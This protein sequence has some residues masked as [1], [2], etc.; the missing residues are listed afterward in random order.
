MSNQAV[1]PMS[2]PGGLDAF[3]APAT[4]EAFLR[5]SFGQSWRHMP[6]A[7]EK[8]A[9]VFSMDEFSRLLGMDVWSARTMTIML[10]GRR[11]PPNAFCEQTVNRT[12]A[13]G[14]YPRRDRVMALMDEG[15]SVVLDEMASL[16]PGVQ[17]IADMLAGAFNARV[18][19]NLYYSQK[20]R[21][22]FA[23]HYDRHEVFALQIVGK[24]R[25]RV[26]RGQEDA[27]IEHPRFLNVPQAEYDKKK[28]QLDREVTTAPGDVLYLP[29]GQFHDA[30]AMDGDSL[31]ITFSVLTP[32]G[33]NLVQD[34]VLR[35][36]DEPL[37]R[38]DLPRPD[39]PDGEAALEQHVDQLVARLADIYSGKNGRDIAKQL[40]KGF[41]SPPTPPYRLPTK[42]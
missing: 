7:P 13:G 35:L 23:S 31:H 1:F 14:L 17:G 30:L 11:A 16:A 34:M 29:R 24:K 27:P 20:E 36:I 8:A 6:G 10:D 38:A 15:A 41:R 39:G 33:L 2:A 9:A 40:I 12:K 37:F 21:R 42:R 5:E 28:G 25:W 18:S 4:A 22:A 3:L 32:M 26:Y 19:A